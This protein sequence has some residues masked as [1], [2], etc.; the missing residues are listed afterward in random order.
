MLVKRLV[1]QNGVVKQGVKSAKEGAK[2][3][4]T[5]WKDK[6]K[7]QMDLNRN[8]DG[9]LKGKRSQALRTGA[10]E[11]L[12]ANIG[13]HSRVI[14]AARGAAGFFGAGTTGN[15][16]FG[17][18]EKARSNAAQQL[19]KQGRGTTTRDIDDYLK[20]E[21]L[22]K[23]TRE[24]KDDELDDVHAQYSTLKD[25]GLTHE[26]AKNRLKEAKY[27]YRSYSKK[28][29]NDSKK[30]KQAYD[31]VY[32]R[33]KGDGKTNAEAHKIAK[34][35]VLD[36]AAMHGNKNPAM[37]DF[38][39]REYMTN[40]TQSDKDAMVATGR[41][42]SNED[43][44]NMLE[45]EYDYIKDDN[46]RQK[47]RV[48]LQA[49][50]TTATDEN[51]Q[52][53]LQREFRYKNNVDTRNKAKDA[54]VDPSKL[55][56]VLSEQY[57]YLQKRGAPTN[58]NTNSI[59]TNDDDTKEMEAE[60]LFSKTNKGAREKTRTLLQL[61]GKDDSDKSVE[62]KMQKIAEKSIKLDDPTNGKKVDQ[63]DFEKSLKLDAIR[64]LKNANSNLT[65][66]KAKDKIDFVL[67]EGKNS[68]D[69]L[70]RTKVAA[71]MAEVKGKQPTQKELTVEMGNLF[72]LKE[73]KIDKSVVE[74]YIKTKVHKNP[75]ARVSS[76]EID[77]TI[78]DTSVYF[79]T[80]RS[81][82]TKATEIALEIKGIENEVASYRGKS[83]AVK[84]AKVTSNMVKSNRKK[85]KGQVN[86]R[87]PMQKD[88]Y[89][90]ELKSALGGRYSENEANRYSE[91]GYQL[92][93]KYAP[94]SI[95][96]KNPKAIS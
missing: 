94:K 14:K 11:A 96:I 5:T 62:E 2:D 7:E 87:K 27:P 10:R 38:G 52:K 68:T 3:R 92:S 85:T 95:N 31:N 4:V 34:N 33:A 15:I 76:K 63:N 42:R 74:N 17:A 1:L 12:R 55:D 39:S 50:G 91:I 93:E 41:T 21:Q 29:F 49:Q 69:P 51:I 60:F 82:K 19:K 8:E 57:D 81:D 61:E 26:E 32:S 73:D 24:F 88:L 40:A 64:D 80:G 13:K 45:L 35:A 70:S 30:V 67:D 18:D 43:V 84:V 56:S 25:S 53:D 36:A 28:D 44:E 66:T 46:N 65:A 9:T 16:L 47:S 22:L 78:L 58:I 75:N 83:E 90:K 77:K 23:D 20:E 6:T 89:K 48:R 54:G 37:P 71:R 59:N 79:D 72:D 86:K